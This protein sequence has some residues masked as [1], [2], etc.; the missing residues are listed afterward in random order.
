MA[1]FEEDGDGVKNEGCA[2]IRDARVGPVDGA[3]SE[4]ESRHNFAEDESETA[5]VSL[6]D[7]LR[8]E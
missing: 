7:A 8:G 1:L 3:E 5:L 6:N 4:V 2:G